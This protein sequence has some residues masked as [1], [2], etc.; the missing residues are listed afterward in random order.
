MLN[1][2]LFS[3]PFFSFLL[4][5]SKNLNA[6]KLFS[7]HCYG[8]VFNAAVV[9]FSFYFTFCQ[10]MKINRQGVVVV[11]GFISALGLAL[12][13]IVM[14]PY[15]N[16]DKYRQIQKINH[17]KMMQMSNTT[18][19]ISSSTLPPWSDPFATKNS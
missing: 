9:F 8:K 6:R 12:Y 11:G 13:P 16:A 4:T 19:P 14:E 15:N 10:I 7:P 3:F 2:N 17:E 18:P 5:Q 1:F